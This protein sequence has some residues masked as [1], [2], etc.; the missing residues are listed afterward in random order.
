MSPKAAK[1]AYIFRG[2]PASGKGTLT[3]LFMQHLKGKVALLELDTF[4]WEFH[5]HVRA[6]SDVTNDEHQFAYENFLLIL[7]RYCKKGDYTIVIEGLFS[8]N[9]PSPHGNMQDILKILKKYGF[10]YE[11]F[12]LSADRDTL[13]E[14]NSKRDYVV[15]HEE[16]DEL[17]DTVMQA[18]GDEEQLIDVTAQSPEETVRGLMKG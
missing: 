15:P 18:T 7:E 14:R 5:S 12:V 4:R 16:F 8:W 9:T 3:K 17:Y 2:P 13:W 1:T 10:T 11:S 6:I